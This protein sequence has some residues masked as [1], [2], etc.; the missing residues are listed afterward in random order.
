MY[1]TLFTESST[2]QTPRIDVGLQLR[3][4]R[5]RVEFS[6]D[7]EK[8]WNA[9]AKLA[10]GKTSEQLPQILPPQIFPPYSAPARAGFVRSPILTMYNAQS[11]VMFYTVDDDFQIKAYGHSQGGQEFVTGVD[12]TRLK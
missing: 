7:A 1:G 4:D 5:I 11:I 9:L 10:E 3:C 8:K 2:G 12:I 6:N